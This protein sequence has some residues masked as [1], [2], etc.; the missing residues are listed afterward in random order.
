VTS[1]QVFEGGSLGVWTQEVGR[2]LDPD[3]SQPRKGN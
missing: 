1:A 3:V 2:E